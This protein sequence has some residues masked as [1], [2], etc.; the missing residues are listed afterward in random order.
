MTLF[1][2]D[3]KP[4]EMERVKITLVCSGL[5][6]SLIQAKGG[7]RHVRVSEAGSVEATLEHENSLECAMFIGHSS[8]GC[9]AM[10]Y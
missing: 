5:E 2:S 8:G 10:A 7:Y 9:H 6:V 4:G 3:G 1:T